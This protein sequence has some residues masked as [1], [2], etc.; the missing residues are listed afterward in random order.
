[1]DKRRRIG[2]E[3]PAFR[4]GTRISEHGYVVLSSKVHG[5]N[6]GRYEHRVLMEQ[7][8]GRSLQSRE[9]VHHRNGDKRDNHIEN[10]SIVTR[11]AHNRLHGGG[12]LRRCVLCGKET[13]CSPSTL[14]LA[15]HGNDD[16]KC[17]QCSRSALYTK[18]CLRCGKMFLGKMPARF[19]ANCTEKRRG[20]S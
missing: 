12:R 2:A 9:I 5:D 10:L 17:R 4:G 7:H 8:L 6:V 11:K 16:Y 20:R 19:C 18:H 15:K 14:K 13:W 1:M 3:H